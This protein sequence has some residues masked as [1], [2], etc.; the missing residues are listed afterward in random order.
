MMRDVPQESLNLLSQTLNVA[1]QN[2]LVKGEFHDQGDAKWIVIR[3]P[4]T[5]HIDTPFGRPT[6][7]QPIGR[8]GVGRPQG[9]FGGLSYY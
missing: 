3:R 4:L 7:G 1:P 6:P 2:L 9:V 8:P 5:G